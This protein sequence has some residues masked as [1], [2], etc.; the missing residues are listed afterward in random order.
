M[1]KILVTGGLGYI[2]SHTVVD[3]HKN[4]HQIIIIDDL[5]NS[6]LKVIEGINEITNSYINFVELDLKD[7]EQTKSFVKENKDI[8]GVI[9]FAASKAVGESVEDPLKY[10]TNNISSL[11]NLLNA[12]KSLERK[13]NF[14]FSSSATVYGK[15]EML[16]ITENE[17]IKVAE[18]PYGNTKQIGEEILHD[19]VKSSPNF[20]VISLRYFNPIGAHDSALIG[21][22]PIGVPQNLVPFITQ[23][24][25]GKREILTVF[26]NDYNTHDGTCLRDYIHVVD[27]A[28]GHVRAF[29]ALEKLSG[30][31]VWNLGTGKGYSVLEIVHAFEE[32]SGKK[33]PYYFGSRR[34]GDV[35]ASY[36]DVTKAKNDLSWEASRG[37]REMMHD[38]WRWQQMNPNGYK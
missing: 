34:T 17:S 11:L 6:S 27:L 25:I 20:N 12:L 22:L 29:D 32:V 30:A 13:I 16:P 10:Y 2:G 1:S 7:F 26:G 23:T 31:H 15:P 8:D 18:S 3:L 5:S 38:T 14:I 33:I 28:D 36:A 21:E 35:S 4:G 24:A 37:L 19:L 9:H